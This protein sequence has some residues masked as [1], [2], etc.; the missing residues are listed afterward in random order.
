MAINKG[1]GPVAVALVPIGMHTI[2]LFQ[3]YTIYLFN[4]SVRKKT[5]LKWIGN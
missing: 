5:T 4:M 1:G 2:P 3:G